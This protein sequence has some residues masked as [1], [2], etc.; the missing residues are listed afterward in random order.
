M[1]RRRKGAIRYGGW[2]TTLAVLA[3]LGAIGWCGHATHWDPANLV[4][5]WHDPA[6][7][8]DLQGG[9]ENASAPTSMASLTA[10]Q[11]PVIEF[12]SA[13]AAKNCGITIG[14]AER[15]PMDE[16]I[17][18]NGEVAYDQTHLAQ[19][20]VR[21]PGVVWR[22]ERRVGDSVERGDILA[23]IDSAD[24]GE[25][26]SHLLEACVEF[27]LKQQTVERLSEIRTAIP[28]RELREAEAQL[29][30]SRA[31]RFIA[32]QK[33]VNLGFPLHF[34]DV[35]DLSVENL[36]NHL[37]LLGLPPGLAK[38]TESAN[39]VPLVAPFAGIITHCE[40]VR[41]ETVDSSK[42]QYVMA[43]V[44]RMW[45]DI[46]V[47]QEDAGRLRLGA[48]VTFETEAAPR[49]VTGKL[50]WIGTEIDS[51][52]HSIRA[53][54]EV[55]NPLLD[56]S[57]EHPASRRLLQAGAYGTAHILITNNPE[58]VAVPADAMHWQWELG[59]E[60]VFIPS[61][62]GRSFTPRVVRK[63][64]ARDGYVQIL[65]GVGV[66]ESIVVAGS[67]VL[68][69]E[70][71]DRLHMHLGDNADGVRDFNQAHQPSPPATQP[72]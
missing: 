29:E 65:E 38:E 66:G 13:A 54:A 32:I 64:L 3:T 23:I 60:L 25:A 34:D 41:G 70:L 51:R 39:L 40:I 15:R 53:R 63:G 20:A 45:I 49:P 44:S 24:I 57:Q 48:T 56:T 9:T 4:N 1:K 7:Q 2:L 6:G 12:P 22:V 59:S 37:L 42:P 68:S 58:T 16:Y 5:W 69:S 31:H 55:E 35:K 61:A 47:R 50:T 67:R 17:R 8:A 43:D 36:H 14:V 27:H 46:D 71:S 18:A 30:L 21:V 33:L 26:K 62:D 19:L 11:L 72:H 10:E 52:T 28:A